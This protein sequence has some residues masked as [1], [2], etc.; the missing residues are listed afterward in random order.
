L[1]CDEGARAEIDPALIGA[2]RQRGDEWVAEG[3]GGAARILGAR[4]VRGKDD[5]EDGER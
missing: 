2:S 5:G 3:I 4:R 1:R